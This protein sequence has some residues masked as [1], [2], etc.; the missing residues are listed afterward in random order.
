[1]I[2]LNNVFNE[3]TTIAL[4]DFGFDVENGFKYNTERGIEEYTIVLPF[5]NA[6]MVTEIFRDTVNTLA[7]ENG[8]Y[9]NEFNDKTVE[10]NV[11]IEFVY[12]FDSD[13]K[14]I[15]IWIEP[16]NKADTEFLDEAMTIVYFT[17]ELDADDEIYLRKSLAEIIYNA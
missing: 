10:Y 17:S 8:Y 5:E 13:T 6:D 14:E 3:K 7:A 11:V 1:M 9:G 12:S 4:S 15:A 2:I 16:V